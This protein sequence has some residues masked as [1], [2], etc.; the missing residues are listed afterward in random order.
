MILERARSSLVPVVVF[1]VALYLPK[2]QISYAQNLPGI[3]LEMDA[4]NAECVGGQTVILYCNVNGIS[5]VA[6]YEVNWT[7]GARLEGSTGVALV[8]LNSERATL[9]SWNS[10]GDT[11]SITYTFRMD[12]VTEA[13]TGVY[14]CQVFYRN[15]NNVQ[16]STGHSWDKTSESTD[17]TVRQA[18]SPLPQCINPGKGD[19]G[20]RRTFY[21]TDENVQFS[22]INRVNGDS[23]WTRRDLG[24]GT[25]LLVSDQNS[26]THT[27]ELAADDLNGT[28]FVCTQFTKTAS[29]GD[30]IVGPIRVLSASL[31]PPTTPPP[32][33]TATTTKPWTTTLPPTKSTTTRNLAKGPE[34]IVEYK[35]NGMGMVNQTLP[36]RERDYLDT[37]PAFIYIL[38][39]T[40]IAAVSI[41][42]NL[43]LIMKLCQLRKGT[44]DKMCNNKHCDTVYRNGSIYKDEYCTCGYML[45]IASQESAV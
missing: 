20:S 7:K 35:P 36:S 5:S 30:C 29:A 21:Y 4:L 23:Q 12:N 16:D 18:T 8:P 2:M 40:L 19:G 24:G 27:V 14:T 28:V 6:E 43:Y 26:N 34:T 45:K 1:I 31:R 13:D 39:P 22:C 11:D 25:L 41:L 33:T 3:T 9:S 37:C 44:V 42:L 10:A 17:V 32:T 15:S 38:L